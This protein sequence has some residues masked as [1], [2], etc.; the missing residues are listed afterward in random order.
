M[1][2][3]NEDDSADDSDDYDYD[4]TGFFICLIILFA[5]YTHT[6]RICLYMSI[7]FCF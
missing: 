6:H 7:S 2:S 5:Q 4:I 1:I 3:S